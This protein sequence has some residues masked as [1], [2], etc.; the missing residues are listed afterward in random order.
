VTVQHTARE[1]WLQAGIALL[2]PWFR[3]VG[4]IDIPEN[5]RV[6]VG[7]GPQGSRQESD[8]IMGGT[9]HT[10]C[11]ADAS[12]EI[13]ISPESADALDML[14]TLVHELVHAILLIRK[15]ALWWG[16][17]GAF[18]EL[19]GRLGLEGP[20]RSSSPGPGLQ[21]ELERTAIAL[22]PYPGAVVTVSGTGPA[23]EP[24]ERAST[25]PKPQTGSRYLL[26]K[27]EQE[28]GEPCYGYQIRITAKWWAEGAPF[29][30]RGHEMTKT[31][32]R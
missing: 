24:A 4:S 12:V 7:F 6:T 9:L 31:P 5:I 22:G 17:T 2:E 21:A 16:H 15:E 11:S 27:C 32:A 13:F 30:P 3:D 19:A 26:A 14:A 28:E 10:R 1:A 8:R 18:A 25:G 20:M 23:P 29:C